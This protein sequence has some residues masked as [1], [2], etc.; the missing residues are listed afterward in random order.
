M[1]TFILTWNPAYETENEKRHI[2]RLRAGTEDLSEWSFST[3][4]KG[5]KEGDRAFMLLQGAERGLVAAG[6]FETPIEVRAHWDGSGRTCGF[7]DV[8]WDRPWLETSDR[9]ETSD[10]LALVPGIKW[11][12]LRGSGVEAKPPADVDLEQAWSIHLRKT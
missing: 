11:N 1:A 9:L 4:T 6:L 2:P 8:R 3:R 5:V 7:A 12:A 10:L